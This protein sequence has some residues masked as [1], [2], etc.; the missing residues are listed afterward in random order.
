M[1]FDKL[2]PKVPKG[3]C[4]SC[5]APALPFHSQCNACRIQSGGLPFTS[6]QQRKQQP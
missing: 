5:G 6:P 2:V 1:D 4:G 3:K